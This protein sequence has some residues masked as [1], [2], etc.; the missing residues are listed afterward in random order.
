M[1]ELNL[2]LLAGPNGAGKSTAA[3]DLLRGALNVHEFVNADEIAR[4]LSAFHPEGAAMAAGRAMLTRFHELTKERRNVAFES[5]LASRTSHRGLASC[6]RW[7]IDSICCILATVSG[8]VYR[9]SLRTKVAGGPF[10]AGEGNSAP[11]RTWASQF[12]RILRTDCGTMG[13]LREHEKATAFDR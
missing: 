8:R 11:L 9:A 4:G 3:P 1:S 13:V 2:I 10:R 5:T 12:L 7:A 6:G